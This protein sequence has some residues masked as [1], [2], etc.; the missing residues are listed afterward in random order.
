MY[1]A[2]NMRYHTQ[3]FTLGHLFQVICSDFTWTQ[4][5]SVNCSSHLD[6]SFG[7]NSNLFIH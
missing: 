6:L 5:L 4:N 3:H 1:N 2:V 7:E